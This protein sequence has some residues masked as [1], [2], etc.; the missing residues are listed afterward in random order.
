[1]V[2]ATSTCNAMCS[3][4]PRLACQGEDQQKFGTSYMYMCIGE[5]R[6]ASA[7][8]DKQEYGTAQW[9]H[10]C[11]GAAAG[12]HAHA[13]RLLPALSQLTALQAA[14]PA[15]GHAPLTTSHAP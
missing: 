9:R 3:G 12:L 11:R 7:G 6:L 2:L 13:Q 14:R 8:E 15:T 4:E 10:V 1:M 5:P